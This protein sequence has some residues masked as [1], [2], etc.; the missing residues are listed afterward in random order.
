MVPDW[1]ELSGHARQLQP[2]V[3]SEARRL[4]YSGSYA[5]QNQF[6]A[7]FKPLYLVIILKMV[8]K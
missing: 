1:T 7:D 8:V 4:Q 2:E 6:E 3:D 5:V